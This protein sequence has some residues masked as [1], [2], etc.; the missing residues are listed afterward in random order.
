MCFEDFTPKLK[1]VKVKLWTAADVVQHSFLVQDSISSLNLELCQSYDIRTSLKVV[2]YYPSF[3]VCK[4]FIDTEEK[5]RKIHTSSRNVFYSLHLDLPK[6][7]EESLKTHFQL[8][9]LSYDDRIPH[10]A[11]V[12]IGDEFYADILCR[13]VDYACKYTNLNVKVLKWFIKFG[14]LKKSIFR[15][16]PFYVIYHFLDSMQPGLSDLVFVE[17]C[18]KKLR[19]QIWVDFSEKHVRVANLFYQVRLGGERFERRIRNSGIIH[20]CLLHPTFL[21]VADVLKYL[22][23]PRFCDRFRVLLE[24]RILEKNSQLPV[25]NSV[26]RSSAR[27]RRRTLLLHLYWTHMNRTDNRYAAASESLRLIWNSLPDPFITL[28]EITAQFRTF[29]HRRIAKIYNFYSLAI[30]EFRTAADIRSL[31]H[32]CRST[33]RRRLWQ[34][35]H[36]LPDGIEKL[37]LNSEY[38]SYLNLEKI[39]FWQM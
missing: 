26:I 16:L 39:D 18:L 29:S 38:K 25:P 30:G 14:A 6:G 33:I 3:S 23:S 31:K 11:K 32:L 19:F 22:D 34:N 37:G 13:L 15:E 4:G 2:G 12:F 1:H 24:K 5:C 35:G 7:R 9:K 36:W 8:D 17:E 21:Y 20:C 10:L 28:E 27:R